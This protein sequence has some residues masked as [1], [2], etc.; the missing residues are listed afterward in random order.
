MELTKKKKKKTTTQSTLAGHRWHLI[1]TFNRDCFKHFSLISPAIPFFW[2]KIKRPLHIY[3]RLF[4]ILSYP[5]PRPHAVHYII[6]EYHLYF[7]LSVSFL[8]LCKGENVSFFLSPFRFAWPSPLSLQ[9][10][11]ITPPAHHQHHPIEKKK[12][13]IMRQQVK[14]SVSPRLST[15]S[16]QSI[17]M[18]H[19]TMGSNPD[20]GENIYVSPLEYGIKC[21]LGGK[22]LAGNCFSCINWTWKEMRRAGYIASAGNQTGPAA[23]Q[24]Q[25]CGSTPYTVYFSYY[26]GTKGT[27]E[28][29]DLRQQM[30]PISKCAPLVCL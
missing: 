3:V 28:I 11:D 29:F 16:A 14:D 5:I 13:L 9:K 17:G 6:G 30:T 18:G 1:Q 19:C 22:R 15:C 8:E 10:G 27:D 25:P 2:T 24:L 20:G 7:F 26:W 4:L 23:S 21:F 12:K